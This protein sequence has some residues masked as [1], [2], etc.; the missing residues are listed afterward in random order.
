VSL[1]VEPPGT[2]AAAISD[3]HAE[4]PLVAVQLFKMPAS[5]LI[6]AVGTLKPV[7]SEAPGEAPV[8][9]FAS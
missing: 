9:I 4:P 1:G 5:V 3:V 8:V 2:V 6:F 7:G